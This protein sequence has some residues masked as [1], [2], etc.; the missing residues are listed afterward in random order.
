MNI[1]DLYEEDNSIDCLDP[2]EEPEPEIDDTF[3]FGDEVDE[4]TVEERI[5]ED[6]RQLA[7]KQL[8]AMM[9]EN[10]ALK[11]MVRDALRVDL[12]KAWI[13]I[14]EGKSTLDKKTQKEVK[15]TIEAIYGKQDKKIEEDPEPTE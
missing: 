1:K 9:E 10:P 4:K 3:D 13:D 11:M 5:A 12:I 2:E 14:E 7:I 6:R 8:T 15:E